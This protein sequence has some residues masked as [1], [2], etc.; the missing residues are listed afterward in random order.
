MPSQVPSDHPAGLDYGQV[1]A[2]KCGW[3]AC[4][5]RQLYLVC[6]RAPLLP[7]SAEGSSVPPPVSHFGGSS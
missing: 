3:P 6:C 4:P 5:A 2:P 7:P 1:A